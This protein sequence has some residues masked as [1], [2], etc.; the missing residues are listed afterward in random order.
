MSFGFSVGDFI[1]VGH[2][3]IKIY[4]ALKDSTG[5]AAEFQSLKLIRGSLGTALAEVR[6]RI[7]SPTPYPIPKS[8]VNAA[9]VLL[10]KCSQHLER[11]DEI[12]R[13]YAVSLAPGGSTN[14][15]KDALR[16]IQWGKTKDETEELFRRFM[17][18]MGMIRTLLAVHNT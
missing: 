6:G 8:L 5:S 2:T 9:T 1:A 7:R 13:D 14:K 3:F 10:D 18:Q 16:K 4:T 15:G 11:F 17:E 12:T